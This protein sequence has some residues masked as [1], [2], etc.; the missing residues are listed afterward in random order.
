M[1]PSEASFSV[2][3]NLIGH[4]MMAMEYHAASVAIALELKLD[5]EDVCSA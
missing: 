5:Y 2:V 1:R 4:P 3:L